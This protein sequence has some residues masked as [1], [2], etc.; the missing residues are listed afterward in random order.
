MAIVEWPDGLNIRS[1][2]WTNNRPSQSNSSPYTGARSVATSPWHGKLSA[3]I[4]IAT[5]VGFD[6]GRMLRGFIASVLGQVNT[7]RVPYTEGDQLHLPAA[8]VGTTAA[9]GATS[10]TLLGVQMQPGQSV[11]VN[12][13]LLQI[14]S[15]ADA[16]IT[17]QPPLRAQA[18][19]TTVVETGDPTVLMA[20]ADSAVSWN[21]EPGPIYTASFDVE[22][23]F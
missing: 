17:F 13:Q 11:T 16:V 19:S 8:T 5:M 9:K 7:F 6:K 1:V 14:L 2:Q 4:E 21:V 18:T 23:V 12:D 20:M 15:V 10:I 22:E 3:K